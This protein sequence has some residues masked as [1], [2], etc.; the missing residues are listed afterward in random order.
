ME[1]VV[2]TVKA[3][4]IFAVVSGT[5]P[6]VVWAERKVMADVQARIGPNRVGPYGIF[7][8]FAD[9]FKL[10]FKEDVTPRSADK[11]LYYLAPVLS[12]IP[13]LTAF[14]VV[15]YG[16]PGL[17]LFGYPAGWVTDPKD[18]GVLF[19]FAVS[20][21]GVY[22][23]VLAG[24][25]SNN[26]YSLLGALRSA[27][28]MVSYEIALGL[29]IMGVV[30][31]TGSLSLV[32]IV[33][34]QAKP[35]W[36]F[37]PGIWLFAQ[38]VA[39]FLFFLASLAETNRTPFDFPEAESELVA[40]FHTEYSS[41]KFAMFFMAEY[42]NVLTLGAVI[43][44]L[45][46]GGYLGPGVSSFPLLGVGYF[47]AKTVLVTYV[48]IWVRATLPR[49]R[50]DQLMRLAWKALL[51]LGLANLFLTALWVGLRQ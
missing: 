1:Y 31:G 43:S 11:A 10:I 8:S 16:P 51:P 37:I 41:F 5:M 48:I 27:A 21:L 47:V 20:S 50:Y 44:T 46:L 9:A 38:P 33:Q 29:S 36:G 6:F 39:F 7:Q 45:F 28:Q 40:G 14:A 34:A 26:K 2:L 35:Y 30:L 42:I 24:W 4:V 13:A 12:M 19:I 22:G 49:F 25:A 3:V 23:I 17:T 32:D 18:V 15:P